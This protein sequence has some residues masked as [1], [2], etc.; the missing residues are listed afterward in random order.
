MP[1]A[2]SNLVGD[3]DRAKWAR[4]KKKL[5]CRGG[6]VQNRSDWSWNKN[7]LGL[8]GWGGEGAEKRCC[9]KCLANFTH[10][11]FTDF[12]A[13]AF[14]RNHL[15]T[16]VLFKQIILASGGHLSNLFGLPG[17]ELAFITADLMH[18]ADLG[19]VQYLI[20]CVLYEL[21]I[22]MNGV[23]TRSAPTLADLLIMIRTA[24]KSL[25]QD[26]LPLNALTMTMIKGNSGPKMKTK[27]SDGRKL[28][29]CVRFILDKFFPG[30]RRTHRRGSRWCI[31]F[32]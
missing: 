3:K 1:F 27:A 4:K 9:W 22:E 24:S 10:L 29:Y 31:N 30:I 18:V 17:F 6:V 13:A 28:L 12:S 19:V 16:T 26:K 7:V 23:M 20:A 32:A 25:K 14:W 11:P 21:F 8:M 2:N 15:L 5:R